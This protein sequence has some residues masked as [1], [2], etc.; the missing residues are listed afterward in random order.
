MDT[1]AQHLGTTAH[2][3]PLLMKA[4]RLELARPEDLETLAVARGCRYYDAEAGSSSR[5]D[6][7]A[8]QVSRE[9]F[10]DVELAM[11]LLSIALP[12]SQ[13]RLRLGGAMLAAEGNKA[14]DILRLARMERC[15]IVT[16]HVARCGA[17]VEPDNPFWR[18]LLAGLPR[19]EEAKPDVLP[20]LT[21]FV[22]MTGLT[23]NG[24]ETVMQWIRPRRAGAASPGHG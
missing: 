3:S 2:M 12:K 21:R 20:H 13:W 16:R 14:E 17:T 9:E 11:A 23:R 18:R 10:S 1:L 5:S 19:T 24:S 6:R 22:A 7:D 8:P 15:E 4:K